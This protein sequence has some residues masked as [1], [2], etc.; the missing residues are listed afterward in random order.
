MLMMRWK[1]K[2]QKELEIYLNNKP[3]EQVRRLKYLSILIDC[4]LT[5][6]EQ[7]NYMTEKCTKLVFALSR[8]AKLNWGLNHAA[9]KTIY[10]GGILPLLLYGAPVW[11]K[12]LDKANF[13]LKLVRFQ[14]LINIK[15]AKAYRTV[16]NEALCIFTG[17]TPIAIKIEEAAQLYQL[18]RGSRKEEAMIY[19]DTRVKHWLHPTETT[20][21]LTDNNEDTSTIQ[22]F[23]DGSKT[24]QGVG[25][26]IAIFKSGI[27]TESLKYRL[28]KR[29]TN[30]Q[31]KQLAILKS[32]EY[33]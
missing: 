7:V 11:M 12:A 26:G 24:E 23:T 5:F 3:L 15:M 13:K 4:K 32:L 28:N 18:T 10:K 2:E 9:L 33:I 27:H 1:Q 25:A 29:W 20:S 21:I 30:N 17:S 31:A 14:R 22:I 16:S 19:L 6:R 8:S